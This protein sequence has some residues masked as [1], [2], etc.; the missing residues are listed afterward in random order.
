VPTAMRR[1]SAHSS[2]KPTSPRLRSA[3]V[4]TSLYSAFSNQFWNAWDMG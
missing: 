3:R 1:R 4:L 2:D